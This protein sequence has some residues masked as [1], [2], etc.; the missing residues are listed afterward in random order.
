MP[1][2][3][4]QKKKLLLIK[5]YLLEYTDETHSVTISDII[6]YLSRNGISA[7]Y[8]SVKDDVELLCD[9]GMDVE[10]GRYIHV[11]SREFELPELKLLVDCVQASKFIT[12]KKTAALTNKLC[13]LCSKY[14]AEGLKRQ[15]HRNRIKSMNESVHVNI[16]NLVEAIGHSRDITFKYMQYT[17]NK[18]M[19][20]RRDGKVYEARPKAIVYSD[21]NYYLVAEDSDT[22]TIKHYRIDKMK[23]IT[24]YESPWHRSSWSNPR[25]T[26]NEFDVSE[27]TKANFAMYGGE[28]R[29]VTMQFENHLIGVVIDRFGKDIPI[30]RVDDKHFETTVSVAVS[31]QFFAWVFGLAGGAK[32]TAPKEVCSEMRHMLKE[33]HEMYIVRHKPKA[34][35]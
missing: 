13:T 18:D 4:G 35:E 34:T 3:S 23:S 10:I 21:E 11:M 31:P 2:V 30:I 8:Q 7:G 24:F 20:L 22:K 12:E 25:R 1:K 9:L 33:V 28:M 29:R 14:E 6:A 15:I 32:I 19:A 5:D 26:R 27:Y 17:L 16:S